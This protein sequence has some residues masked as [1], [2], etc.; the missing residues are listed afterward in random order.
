MSLI[1]L[2]IPPSLFHRRFRLLWLGLGISV[3][4]SQMQTWSLLWHISKLSKDPIAL[5]GI[6]AARIVP[7]LF[8]SLIAGA[9]ADI[10]NRRRIMFLTQL[11]MALIA[12]LLGWL[13]WAGEI[14]IWHI[15][16]LTAV[17]SAAGAFD[18][19]ARQALVPNLVPARDLPN[20]FSMTSITFQAGSIIGPALSG[21]VI[22]QLGLQYVYWI[23]AVS[24]LAV[25]L[26]L[27][28]MGP[29]EQARDASRK[30]AVDLAS[31]GEGVRFIL[32]QPI[33]LATMLLDFI[34]TFFASANVLL[35]KIT[36][37][38]LGLGE[39]A[40]GWLSASQAVGAGL[41]AVVISQLKEIKRQGWV[42]LVSVMIFGA[43]TALFGFAR[44]F[45]TAALFLVVIGASDSVSTIIRNTIR[46]LQT[47]DRLRGRMVSV[48]QMFFMGGPQLGEIEAGAAAQVFGV[49]FAV[50]S[51]GVA[52]ILAV[53]WVAR[54]WPQLGSYNGDEPV[55]AG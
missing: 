30:V 44:S 17:Q 38:V 12:A 13:T 49:P 52:C 21:L 45:W 15:Y 36:T 27:L 39:T 33:I 55:A 14:T 19:P 28:R 47:P 24:F 50:V 32:G 35:P 54:R 42:F 26:A 41:A 11:A 6:G 3:A 51:G 5:G 34:A 43:A 29:V 37:D 22:G 40:Y 9:V 16:L 18:L 20:A 48:N 46:Q 10:A 23:N 7:V 25:L 8:F 2:R 31:I 4:G 1:N 53:S